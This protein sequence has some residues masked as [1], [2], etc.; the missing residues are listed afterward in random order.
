MRFTTIAALLLG[1]LI[2]ICGTMALHVDNPGPDAGDWLTFAGALIGVVFTITGT[3]W[4]E[5][6]RASKGE[7]EDKQLLMKALDEMR[8]AL[9]QVNQPRGDAPIADAQRAWIAREQALRNSFNKFVYARHYVPK[10]N[11]EAWRAV[12]ELNDAIT[13][14]RPELEKELRHLNEDGHHE[15]VL[16]VSV[17]KMSEIHDRLSG[18]LEAARL[19]VENHSP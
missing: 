7:R 9:G 6:Y 18:P 8:A 19:I 13:R 12:E 14:E 1:I 16:T 11:I 2:G 5:G 10:R 3:L 4:L 17:N 15:G